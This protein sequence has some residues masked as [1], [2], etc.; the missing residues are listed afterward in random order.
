[1]SLDINTAA[2]FN[3]IFEENHWCFIEVNEILKK[4]YIKSFISIRLNF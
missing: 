3:T 2:I 1:M 4:I